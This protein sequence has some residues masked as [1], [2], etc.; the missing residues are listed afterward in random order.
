MF[1]YRNNT[2][3]QTPAVHKRTRKENVNTFNCNVHPRH[4]SKQVFT[5]MKASNLNSHANRR[6]FGTNLTNKRAMSRIHFDPTDHSQ[7]LQIN[8]PSKKIMF[9]TKQTNLNE[10]A[11][12]FNIGIK[13]K[14]KFEHIEDTE[15]C[16]T[17]ASWSPSIKKTFGR[18]FR[19]AFARIGGYKLFIP[20]NKITSIDYAIEEDFDEVVEP[21]LVL[22][23]YDTDSDDS[24][25]PY[26]DVPRIPLVCIVLI[27]YLCYIDSIYAMTGG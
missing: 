6:R 10:S 3:F 8:K 27:Q 11:F 7:T 24:V 25:D 18:I 20:S 19:K 2:P 15:H 5:T 12:T 26:F 22:N 1:N 23:L 4:E 14:Q 9:A 21:K 16:P 13:Q 17:S